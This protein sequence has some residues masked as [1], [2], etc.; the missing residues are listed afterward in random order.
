MKQDILFLMSLEAIQIILFWHILDP[1]PMCLLNDPL[2]RLDEQIRD[3]HYA[4]CF[5][6]VLSISQF[7]GAY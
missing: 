2:F 4:L 6:F 3:V 7:L 5:N 1:L